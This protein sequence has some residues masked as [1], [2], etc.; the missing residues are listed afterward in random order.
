MEKINNFELFDAKVEK[1]LRNKMTDKE[2]NLFM[3]ELASDSELKERARITALM[4]KTMQQEGM[5]QDVAI[6]E[7][8]QLMDEQ[9]FRKALGLKTRI[10]R[11]WPR[12]MKLVAAACIVGIILFGGYHYYEYDRTIS[13]GNNHYFAYVQDI[14]DTENIR[15][16]IDKAKL[17]E[18]ERLFANV[19]E[20]R[21]IA[22]TILVLERLYQDSFKD[23]SVYFDFQDDISWNLAIAYLKNGEREKPIP[24]LENMLKRNN[25]YPQIT[26][27]VQEL[28]KKIKDL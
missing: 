20:G 8:I 17:K 7:K 24:I 4:I 28:I 13:L 26:Q 16:N 10:L 14:S 6:V 18:L 9:D 22:P 27:P 25:D 5:K 23:E 15:G 1:Y 2:E 21:E 11:V 12:Y 19:K 3:E